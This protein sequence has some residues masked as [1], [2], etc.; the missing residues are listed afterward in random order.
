MYLSGYG[1]IFRLSQAHSASTAKCSCVE[2]QSTFTWDRVRP[3]KLLTCLWA[4]AFVSVTMCH[5]CEK[6]C[7]TQCDTVPDA[8]DPPWFPDNTFVIV[9]IGNN[10]VCILKEIHSVDSCV[11]C[12]ICALFLLFAEKRLKL[13]KSHTSLG[14]S[15]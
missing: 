15:C 9:R 4:L 3:N 8:R 5:K 10:A 2:R 12:E 11:V 6:W 7:C 14:L 1:T 13:S